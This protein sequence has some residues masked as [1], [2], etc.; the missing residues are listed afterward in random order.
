MYF[1]FF[2]LFNLP[3]YIHDKFL[4]N[5]ISNIHLKILHKTN[6]KEIPII[7]EFQYKTT[8][9]KNAMIENYHFKNNNFRKVSIS[10][11]KSD[12]QQIFSSEWYPSYDYDCP[13]LTIHTINYGKEESYFFIHLEQIYSD[14]TYQK[15]YINPF[16][17]LKVNNSFIK[18]L[19]KSLLYCKL[20]NNEIEGFIP[21]I[22]EKYFDIYFNYFI[23]KPVNRYFIEEKHREYSIIKK[24]KELKYKLKKYF[25][26]DWYYRFIIE[27][28]K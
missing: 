21:I 20:N 5:N 3:K 23:K 19:G 24:N 11:F 27:M 4:F 8:N 14:N 13:I 2:Y 25:K 15:K 1:F 6:F 12:D 7:S 10:Y 28:N 9:I 16:L 17:E 26:D 18:S 22:L